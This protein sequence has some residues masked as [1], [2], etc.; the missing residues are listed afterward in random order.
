MNSN[1]CMVKLM[2]ALVL[3]G[4]GGLALAQGHNNH[5]GHGAGMA[6][7]AVDAM[8]AGEIRRVDAAQGKL[9]IRHEEIKNIMMPPMTMVFTL[10]DPQQM[11]DLKVGDKVMFEVV[12]QAG[13]L[14]ITKIKKAP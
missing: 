2:V 13:R 10:Q 8:T 4:A 9:T 12:D 1:K 6:H 3:T 5:G 11:Q 7:A 14:M